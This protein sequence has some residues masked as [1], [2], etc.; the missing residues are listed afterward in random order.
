MSFR[1]VN[2]PDFN[3]LA[4]AAIEGGVKGVRQGLNILQRDA[5]ETIRTKRFATGQLAQSLH[6]EVLPPDGDNIMGV[7]GAEAPYAPFVEY[8]TR[9]HIAPIGAFNGWATVK[10]FRSTGRSF[11]RGSVAHSSLAKAGWIAVKTKGTKGIH[12]MKHAY[13]E[14]GNEAQMKVAEKV[15]GEISDYAGN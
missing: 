5:A 11:V 8:D 9:P 2:K 12:F 6:S 7:M 13:E 3:G 15:K 14:K 1:I 4:R 10:G